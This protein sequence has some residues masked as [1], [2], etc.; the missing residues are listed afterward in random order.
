MAFG[1]SM[2]MR[3]AVGNESDQ[4][5]ECKSQQHHNQLQQIRMLVVTLMDE[6]L[7]E[8]DLKVVDISCKN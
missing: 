4:A 6:D 8:C 7:E 2:R 1:S 3:V 5:D